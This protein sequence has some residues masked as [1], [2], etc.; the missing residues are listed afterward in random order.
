[1]RNVILLFCFTLSLSAQPRYLS[2][3]DID[4]SKDG[5]TLYLACTT[6]E[7]IQLFDVETE[8]VTSQFKVEGIRELVLS[9]DESR[10]FAVCGEFN[11]KLL[12]L[13]ATNGEV[14]RS[15]PAGHTPMSPVMSADGK[16]LFFCNRFSRADQPDVHAFDIASGKIRSSAKAIREPITMKLSKDGKFLWVVNHLPLMEA[17]REHVFASLNIYNSADLKSVAKLDMPPGSEPRRPISVCLTHRWPIHR[18][19]NPPRPGL[20]QYQ[21]RLY[22]RCARAAIYQH[23]SSGRCHAGRREPLGRHGHR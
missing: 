20:G 22:F 16:T 2:P 23:R 19:H 10:I 12:E 7:C 18:S 1:M 3:S 9:P 8:K 13:D 5:S 15:F 21:R 17:N 11:G 6:G 14:I 4:V